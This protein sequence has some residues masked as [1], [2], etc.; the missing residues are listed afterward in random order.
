MLHFRIMTGEQVVNI[1]WL[2]RK[3]E[4]MLLQGIP[5]AGFLTFV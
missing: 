2:K 5:A 1:V 4:K 3:K